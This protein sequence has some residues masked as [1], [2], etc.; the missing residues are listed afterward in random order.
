MTFLEN[1]TASNNDSFF[2]ALQTR[3][4]SKKE[5]APPTGLNKIVKTP[6]LAPMSFDE[7]MVLSY[8]SDD[9]LLKANSLNNNFLN[10][11]RD[12]TQKFTENLMNYKD[13]ENAVFS[14]IFQD[15]DKD[16]SKN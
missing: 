8:D 10:R 4:R 7:E 13:N 14:D 3:P 1:E 16:Y 15:L 6:S 12:T 5:D 2:N 11:E 9:E